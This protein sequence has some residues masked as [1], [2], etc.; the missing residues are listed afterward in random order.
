MWQM[1]LSQEQRRLNFFWFSL[2]IDKNHSVR[3]GDDAARVALCV[4]DVPL[5]VKPLRA[6]WR[7]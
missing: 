1:R 7:P 3:T 2:E 4:S 5:V 6:I